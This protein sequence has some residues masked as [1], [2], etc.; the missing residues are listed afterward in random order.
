MN[1][2]VNHIQHIPVIAG[3]SGANLVITTTTL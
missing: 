1:Y 2:P 3:T